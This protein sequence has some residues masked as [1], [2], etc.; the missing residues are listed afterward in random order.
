MVVSA[1]PFGCSGLLGSP[2]RWSRHGSSILLFT[3]RVSQQIIIAFT[4]PS[5][6]AGCSRQD[7]LHADRDGI[8]VGHIGL[9]ALTC[10]GPGSHWKRFIL[11]FRWLDLG[12]RPRWRPARL[13]K[14][15]LMRE[16]PRGN[17]I[18]PARPRQS[19][20]IPRGLWEITTAVYHREI[21]A[22]SLLMFAGALRSLADIRIK[23]SRNF[24]VMLR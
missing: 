15:C 3:H 24:N 11:R 10:Y 14:I 12:W 5:G 16:A 18:I 20:I 13:G 8:E 7:K 4:F 21:W 23:L 2:W 1:W 19:N 9:P 6:K 22:R 17:V